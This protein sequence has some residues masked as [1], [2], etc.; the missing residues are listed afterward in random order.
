MSI[1]GKVNRGGREETQRRISIIKVLMYEIADVRE[2]SGEGI[3]AD[4][5]TFKE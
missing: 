2:P 3:D 5:V 1:S 4:R